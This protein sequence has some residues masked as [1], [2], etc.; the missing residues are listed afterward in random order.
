MKNNMEF[1]R[2]DIAI[3]RD[4]QIDG[5][6]GQ[7]I[8]VYIETWFDVDKKFGISTQADDAWLNMYGRYNPYADT[9]YIECEETTDNS[10]EC[11]EYK[12]TDAEAQ[13]IKQMIAEKIREEYGQTPQEFCDE[14]L[15]DQS[16]GGIS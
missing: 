13:L 3:D 8:L 12:P 6:I 1:E 11:F 2:S 10:S 9:L 5:D 16:I 7:E 14:F 4:M 15:D